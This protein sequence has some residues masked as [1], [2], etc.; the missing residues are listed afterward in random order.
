MDCGPQTERRGQGPVQ[1]QRN[2]V[3]ATL[4]NKTLAQVRSHDQMSQQEI[5]KVYQVIEIP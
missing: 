4:S 2:S 3:A 5:Y 1:L